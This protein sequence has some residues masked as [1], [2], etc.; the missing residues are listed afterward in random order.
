M[1]FLF[2]FFFYLISFTAQ[3]QANPVKTTLPQRQT[4]LMYQLQA[5]FSER[6]GAWLEIHYRR[7]GY[8]MENEGTQ[9]NRLAL[10]YFPTGTLR[11]SA[12]YA[13]ITLRNAFNTGPDRPEHRTWAEVSWIQPYPHL[14]LTQRFRAEQRWVHRADA[15]RLQ[16]GYRFNHRLRYQLGVQIPLWRLADNRPGLTLV[17]NEEV[18]LNA[19]KEILYNVFDQN[20]LFAGFAFPLTPQLTAQTGYLWLYQQ[21]NAGNTFL[22]MDIVR[23]TLIQN[24][25]FRP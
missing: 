4:W 11:L 16:P 12:N 21:Q 10:T 19:G 3:S 8:A 7:N 24:L 22:D 23:F 14:L 2:V 17:A 1:R 13:Y 6:W 5:R 18:L 25:D 15:K 9:L 20:Q